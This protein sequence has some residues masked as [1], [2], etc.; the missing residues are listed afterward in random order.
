MQG[1]L[2]D[3]SVFGLHLDGQG[4]PHRDKQGCWGVDLS[5]CSAA[6]C[7]KFEILVLNGQVD[8]WD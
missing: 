7:V 4:G 2:D 5:R 3:P 1:V 8:T 6:P